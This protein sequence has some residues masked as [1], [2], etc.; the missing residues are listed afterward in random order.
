[1]SDTGSGIFKL[2]NTGD[3]KENQKNQRNL[4]RMVESWVR[5]QAKKLKTVR[6]QLKFQGDEV[7][8][9]LRLL[10]TLVHSIDVKDQQ[11]QAFFAKVSQSKGWDILGGR[12]EDALE[13]LYAGEGIL[14]EFRTELTDLEAE[15]NSLYKRIQ[16]AVDEDTPD[17]KL[18]ELKALNESIPVALAKVKGIKE[19]N[20]EVM[21]KAMNAMDG[22]WQSIGQYLRKQ[23][24]RVVAK[25]R[26]AETLEAADNIV[27]SVNMTLSVLEEADP[28]LMA[29]KSIAAIKWGISGIKEAFK[30]YRIRKTAK[31][32]AEDEDWDKLG[33]YAV[34]ESKL[35]DLK[36]IIDLFF[37]QALDLAIPKWSFI[38]PGIKPFVHAIIDAPV[39][40][41]KQLDKT[42]VPGIIENLK[43][44]LE[45]EFKYKSKLSL[46]KYLPPTAAIKT[47]E[48]LVQ[49]FT[50]Q[51]I[52]KLP[53]EPAQKHPG[54]ELK[55]YRDELRMCYAAGLRLPPDEAIAKLEALGVKAAWHDD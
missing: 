36:R 21:S 39:T 35:G 19:H 41:A 38:E 11:Y 29:E 5:E 14:L 49:A 44:K 54:V 8:D 4:D 10:A 3:T 40:K 23:K 27:E 22:G 45:E 53:I 24:D 1:M 46:T 20:V 16:T 30:E 12:P 50:E 32:I 31:T 33:P 2:K 43:E 47:L 48:I 37:L 55:Q 52:A 17:P 6:G 9:A 15:L 51:V 18:A 25:L 13:E 26:E 42:K 34:M 28:T 7:H